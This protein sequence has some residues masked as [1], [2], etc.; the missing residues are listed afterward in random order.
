MVD[1]VSESFMHIIDGFILHHY[2]HLVLLN[3]GVLPCSLHLFCSFMSDLQDLPH[4]L[5]DF[6]YW[7]HIKLIQGECKCYDVSCLDIILCFPCFIC[8]LKRDI[9]FF[10]P[11]VNH[12]HRNKK[13]IYD[14]IPNSSINRFQKYF[15]SNFPKEIVFFIEK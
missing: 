5:C 15:H 7:D 10:I 2:E 4:F 12:M 8:C 14:S 1:N 9:F 11:I 13:T 6:A 3:Q